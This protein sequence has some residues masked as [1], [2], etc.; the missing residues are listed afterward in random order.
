MTLVT[1]AGLDVIKE[2]ALDA[3]DNMAYMAWGS[4]TTQDQV[5]DTTLE[6]EGFRNLFNTTS[7]KN[8]G[9]GTY[10]FEGRIPIPQFNGPTA[11]EVGIFVDAIGGDMGI[12][13]L[14]PNTFV[15][16]DNDEIIVQLQILVE[17]VNA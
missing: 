12:R 9:A 17:E 5:S 3:F 4:G 1:T 16:T 15:K 13:E 14:F 6:T 8:I 7:V 11:A 10:L 2:A